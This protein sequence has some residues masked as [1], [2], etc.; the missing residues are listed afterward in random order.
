MPSVLGN[1][2]E[3]KPNRSVPV[4]SVIRECRYACYDNPERRQP[5]RRQR[6]NPKNSGAHW[7]CGHRSQ[8]HSPP[9]SWNTTPSRNNLD[10]GIEDRAPT[11]HQKIEEQRP[12]KDEAEIGLGGRCLSG[13]NQAIEHRE[14][15]R[16]PRSG[17][18]SDLPSPLPAPH[19]TESPHRCLY[20]SQSRRAHP[21]CR[22]RWPCS[23]QR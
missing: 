6:S 11:I 22:I 8:D 13:G 15:S 20:R 2:F 14:P 7:N 16:L 17:R 12:Q 5:C 19:P 21:A 3:G 4:I 1:R 10:P 9:R 23:S 18:G